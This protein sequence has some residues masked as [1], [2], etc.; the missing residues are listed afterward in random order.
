MPFAQDCHPTCLHERTAGQV[1]AR[2]HRRGPTGTGK[3]HLAI[4]ASLNEVED[5]KY[6]HLVIARPH[7][8]ERGEVVTAQTRADTAYD[9]QFAAIEDELTDLVGPDE[10]K[11]L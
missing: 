10:L 2:H 7:V 8:F 5:G 11:R 1:T 6:R 9:G 4:A 3:T